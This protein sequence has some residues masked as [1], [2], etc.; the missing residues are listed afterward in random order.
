MLPRGIN[1]AGRVFVCA[2]PLRTQRARW[3]WRNLRGEYKNR[4]GAVRGDGLRH[5]RIQIINFDERNS[6]G[7][8]Y[9]A[10]NRGVV[11]RCRFAIIADSF[12]AVGTWPLF[13]MSLT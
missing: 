11:A 9:A 13:W 2:L 5:S 3:T 10:H 4:Y 1:A 6:G 8:A 7:V 12:A